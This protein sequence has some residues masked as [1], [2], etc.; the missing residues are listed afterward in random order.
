MAPPFHCQDRAR[1]YSF[2][3]L[4]TPNVSALITADSLFLDHTKRLHIGRVI[5]RR[6]MCIDLTRVLAM[7]PIFLIIR[8]PHSLT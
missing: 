8:S 5:V 2:R 3:I 1:T 4:I 7:K 6:S